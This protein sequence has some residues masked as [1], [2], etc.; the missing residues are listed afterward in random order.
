MPDNIN[1]DLDCDDGDACN[2]GENRQNGLCH[3]D[4]LVDCSHTAYDCNPL[5]SCDPDGVGEL[6]TAASLIFKKA[7]VVRVC[8][9]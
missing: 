8:S 6:T 1:G 4:P 3:S 2:T 5:C 7:T 9:L